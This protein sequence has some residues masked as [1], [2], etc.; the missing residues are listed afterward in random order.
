[1][2]GDEAV[3]VLTQLVW[4][5]LSQN[6]R[7]QLI[8]WEGDEIFSTNLSGE[9]EKLQHQQIGKTGSSEIIPTCS[10]THWAVPHVQSAELV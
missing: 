4:A 8:K 10:S 1:M 5:T 2:V 6:L 9:E 7:K 3:I